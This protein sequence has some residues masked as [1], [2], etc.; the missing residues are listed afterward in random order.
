MQSVRKYKHIYFDLDR[1]IWDFDGNSV[2]TLRD[3]QEKF[4]LLTIGPDEF[5]QAFNYYNE[6]HWK[7][8][9]EGKINKADLRHERFKKTLKKFGIHDKALAEK[10][11]VEYIRI[12]PTQTGLVPFAEEILGQLSSKYSLYIIT[13]GFLDIQTNKLKNSGVYSYFKKIFTAEHAH[14]S[15]PNQRI[16]EYA[17]KSVNAKKKECLMIGDDLELDILGAKAY[18]IDQVYYNPFCLKHHESVTYEI[19][20]LLELKKILI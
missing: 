11:S 4:D 19:N 9:R 20:S 6:Q 1:T 8:F 17:L 16:F 5:H 10:I 13:N 12:G 18:G 3:I 7:M 15:K 14:A 2:Q